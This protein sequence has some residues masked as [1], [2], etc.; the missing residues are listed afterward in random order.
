MQV[1]WPKAEP[2]VFITVL[3]LLP[4]GSFSCLFLEPRLRNARITYA[5]HHIQFFYVGSGI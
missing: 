4:A 2:L 1:P 5:R 3:L